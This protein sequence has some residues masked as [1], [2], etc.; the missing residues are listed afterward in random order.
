M[1]VRMAGTVCVAGV[2]EAGL[3]L[4]APFPSR[5]SGGVP[6]LTGLVS[7]VESRP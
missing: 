3:R 1:G 4:P 7:R 5:S 2:V 6:V